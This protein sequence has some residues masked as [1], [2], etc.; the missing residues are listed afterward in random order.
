[1]SL[2]CEILVVCSFTC[3]VVS[4]RRQRSD[5]FGLWVKLPSVT[6]SRTTQR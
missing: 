1:M 2:E 5:R 6:T 4:A 3:Q